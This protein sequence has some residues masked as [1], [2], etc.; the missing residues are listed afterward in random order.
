VRIRQTKLW[1]GLVALLAALVTPKVASAACVEVTQSVG[2]ACAIAGSTLDVSVTVSSACAPAVQ[3]LG[4]R[5][6]LPEG[7]SYVG[8]SG[9]A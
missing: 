3:A 9:A 4:L 1:L 7:W 6:T 2:G 8:T 5:V